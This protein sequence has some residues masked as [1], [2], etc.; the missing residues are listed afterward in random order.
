MQLSL[1]KNYLIDNT[2]EILGDKFKDLFNLSF[3]DNI[4]EHFTL[5]FIDEFIEPK[6]G[7]SRDVKEV[8]SYYYKNKFRKTKRNWFNSLKKSVED[9]PKK[10]KELTAEIKFVQDGIDNNFIDLEKNY[11]VKSLEDLIE[12]RLKEVEEWVNDDNMLISDYKYIKDKTKRQIQ[13]ALNIDFI[14]TLSDFVIEQFDGD[15]NSVVTEVNDFFTQTPLP[16]KGIR[17]TL[18][19]MNDLSLFVDEYANDDYKITTIINQDIINNNKRSL[20]IDKK[21]W[22]IFY[23]VLSRRDIEFVERKKIFVNI[24][25]LVKVAYPDSRGKKEYDLV[26]QRLEKIKDISFKIEEKNGDIHYFD[27]FNHII[28]SHDGL[29]AEIEV[30]EFFHKQYLNNQTIKIYSD[31]IK[32]FKHEYS[33]PIILTLVSERY[34]YLKEKDM[35]SS[36]AY[37]YEFFARRIRFPSRNKA[38]NLKIIDEC[39][40]EIV[41][42]EVTVQKFTRKKDVYYITFYPVSDR[43]AEDLIEGYNTDASISQIQ[44]VISE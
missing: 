1:A 18:K 13:T 23:F 17:T 5:L 38:D 8:R 2:I 32:N 12:L 34:R 16:G 36:H 37:P 40:E 11:G 39:L 6:T 42:N 28:L 33:E 19:K 27:L 7:R 24:G 41:E 44:E 29:Q 20:Y 14:I 26:I 22:E 31:K 21:D 30:A 15:I 43:E 10:L 25:D 9:P 35:R 3:D 4:L